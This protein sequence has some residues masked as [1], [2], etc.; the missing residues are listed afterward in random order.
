MIVSG[1]FCTMGSMAFMRAGKHT[2][3]H[4]H[5]HIYIYI[6]IHIYDICMH[7]NTHIYTHIHTH[8]VHEDPPMRPLF[9]AF[10]HTQSDELLGSWL[11]LLAG[12]P[13]VPYRYVCMC[14]CVY[15]CMCLGSWLFL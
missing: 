9:G 4:I 5:T 10:R 3:I 15:V 8:T 14:V 6:H 2:H 13:V 12:L 1:V 7:I 11:F